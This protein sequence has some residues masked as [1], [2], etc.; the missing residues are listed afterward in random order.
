[1]NVFVVLHK[2]VQE[3]KHA[4]KQLDN[5]PGAPLIR[6]VQTPARL[7]AMPESVFLAH[8]A[9]REL[10]SS[11]IP[12]SVPKVNKHVVLTDS[13]K[14]VR[15]SINNLVLRV[16][17]AAKVNVFAALSWHDVDSFASTHETTQITVEHVTTNVQIRPS[18]R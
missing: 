7:S 6:T 14:I 11:Q 16:S 18:V 9:T 5:V 12:P 2:T 1:M 13:G 15:S 3:A 17:S 4:T 8:Q 10:A